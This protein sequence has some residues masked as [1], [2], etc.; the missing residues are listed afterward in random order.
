MITE[1]LNAFDGGE[2]KLKN[3]Y[4]SIVNN[5]WVNLKKGENNY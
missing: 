2:C 4:K 5:Y 1:I 3:R